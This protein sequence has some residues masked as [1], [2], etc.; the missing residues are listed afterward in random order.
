MREDGKTWGKKEK[1][2]KTESKGQKGE[3]YQ[4]VQMKTSCTAG[5]QHT[6]TLWK[7][8]RKVLPGDGQ[9]AFGAS[10]RGEE[11]LD[12]LLLADPIVSLSQPTPT[13]QQEQSRVNGME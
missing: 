10:N 6:R 11:N 5:K 13:R 1:K 12:V 8:G 3:K 4:R 7:P 9:R 2:K